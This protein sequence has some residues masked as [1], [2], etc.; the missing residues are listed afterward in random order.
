MAKSH[1]QKGISNDQKIAVYYF[2]GTGNTQIVAGRIIDAFKKSGFEASLVKIET[3]KDVFI[4]DSDVVGVG[5]PV[6]GFTTFPIVFNFL[7][8]IKK[9]NGNQI[10]AFDTIAGSSLWGI[11]GRLKDIL[12]KKG[13]QTIGYREF[14]MPINIFFEFPKNMVKQRLQKSNMQADDFVS[15]LIVGNTVWKKTPILSNLM[16]YF[17]QMLFRI[18]E[19][20]WHQKNFKMKVNRL[21]CTACGTC[22]AKCPVGNISVGEFAKINDHCQYCFR[23]VGI[24]PEQAI[25]GIVS[26]SS[27]HYLAEGA[28]F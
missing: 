23:C 28:R 19:Y 10:F 12:E 6:A 17:S 25:S 8:K 21:K 15:Q 11:M 14:L 22:A 24:C 9:V 13:F 20:K 27:L 2:S 5:F 26:P 3:V 18:T 7:E 16:P 1:Q 4:N